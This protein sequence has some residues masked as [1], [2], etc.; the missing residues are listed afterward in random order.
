LWRAV[1]GSRP[2]K[3]L[4]RAALEFAGSPGLAGLKSLSRAP[5]RTNGPQVPARAPIT[6][7]LGALRRCGP[8]VR[9]L[10]R[11]EARG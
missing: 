1:W 6:L 4:T 3:S 9:N 8:T 10:I 2:Y 7:P 11:F 5:L